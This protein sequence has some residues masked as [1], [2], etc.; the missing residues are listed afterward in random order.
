MSALDEEMDAVA[1]AFGVSAGQV[2]RDRLISHTLAAISRDVGLD[3]LIFFGGTALSQTH[4]QGVRMSEDIDLIATGHRA[5]IAATIQSAVRSLRR[6][7]GT[8]TWEPPLT[9]TRETE[10]S[11]LRI[12]GDLSVRV[13]LLNQ[14]GYPQWPTEVRSIMQRYSDA[15]PARLRVL[16]APAFA[17]AKLSAWLDRH[18]SRD[19]YDLYAMARCD[20]ITPESVNLFTRHG[21]L[22]R[23][24]GGWA[25]SELPS[26]EQWRIDL[27]HQLRLNVGPEE[28]ARVVRDAWHN[29]TVSANTGR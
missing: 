26:L 14:A 5:T 12:D 3:D 18:A 10:P 6:T 24:P 27:G 25:W 29:A 17:A 11:V 19:L 8:A 20:L 9:E 4:L 16:T 23:L 22:T 13:Q 28:A 7:H 1:A 21:S 15:P 2:A